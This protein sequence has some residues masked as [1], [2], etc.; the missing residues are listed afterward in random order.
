MQKINY[1]TRDD[2]TDERITFDD[3]KGRKTYRKDTN[4]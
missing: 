1:D 3:D 2:D 4:A